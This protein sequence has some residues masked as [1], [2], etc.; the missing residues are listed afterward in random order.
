MF[1]MEDSEE[2]ETLFT[3]NFTNFFVRFVYFSAKRVPVSPP[4][5]KNQQ[6]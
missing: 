6:S 5:R 2:K 1:R 3:F 4:Y